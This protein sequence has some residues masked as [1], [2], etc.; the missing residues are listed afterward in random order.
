MVVNPVKEESF[1]KNIK[2]LWLQL[3]F[4]ALVAVAIPCTA[5]SGGPASEGWELI[6]SGALLID[7]RSTEEF[8]EGHIEGA[9]NIPHDQ[10]DALAEAIGPDPQRSVVLYCGSGRRAGLAA[11]ALQERGYSAVHNAMGYKDLLETRP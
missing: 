1:M 3:L 4:F 11:E 7:V 2:V 9:I 5:G 8:S 6:E 10:T